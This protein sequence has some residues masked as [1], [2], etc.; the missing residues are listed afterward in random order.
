M[1]I[2]ISKSPF[3]EDNW[4]LAVGGCGGCCATFKRHFKNNSEWEESNITAQDL[5]K[6]EAYCLEQLNLINELRA[7][8]AEKK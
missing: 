6:A 1:T 3:D 8:L 5:D 7:I 4:D 2:H